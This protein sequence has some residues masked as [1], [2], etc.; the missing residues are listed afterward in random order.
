LPKVEIT[1]NGHEIDM[2]VDD[3]LDGYDND[4]DDEAIDPTGNHL[5][6]KN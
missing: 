3:D 5:M 1:A 2:D 4:N 6:M